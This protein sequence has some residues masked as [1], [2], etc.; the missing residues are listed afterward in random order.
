M[1][2]AVGMMRAVLDIQNITVRRR[3]GNIF[4]RLT[5]GR[6]KEITL[7]EGV[8]LAIPA[9]STLALVG[10][11]GSGK[12]TLAHTVVGLEPFDEGKIVVDGESGEGWNLSWYGR[13]WQRIRRKIGITFQDAVASLDPRMTVA[14]SIAAPFRIHGIRGRDLRAEAAALL[15]QVGLARAFLDRYPHQLSGGQARRVS[16]ARAIALKPQ[17]LI[18]DEPTAG[19]DLSVQGEVLN[20]LSGLRTRLGL[21]C[22]LIT[23]NL[24]VARHMAER[25][26][27]MYLGRIVEAGPATAVFENPAHPYTKA[28]LN[29]RGGSGGKRPAALSGEVPSLAQRPLGCEFSTRCP[30]A[31][32]RCR[33]EAPIETTIKAG[34]QVRCHFP[35]ISTDSQS[36]WEDSRWLGGRGAVA[37]R[38]GARLAVSNIRLAGS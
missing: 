25:V 22:L 5:S 4:A 7:I 28:L 31:Q 9:G 21:G 12:T 20:L 33:I 14:A 26:A 10:E 30:V 6:A 24:P 13:P 34:H 16:I 23:H 1:S 35:S 18:A 15:D 37:G 38:K 3:T 29:A 11:S 19:L 32:Q 27:I 17:L 2:P 36:L 8:S